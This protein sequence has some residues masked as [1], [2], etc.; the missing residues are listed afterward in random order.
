MC[1]RCRSADSEV[2]VA[3]LQSPPSLPADTQ[4]WREVTTKFIFITLTST[5]NSLFKKCQPSKPV[6]VKIF[7][8]PDG[9]AAAAA[10]ADVA[11]PPVSSS[12]APLVPAASV[13]SSVGSETLG[14]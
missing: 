12:P 6:C 11:R 1:V 2:V 9:A 13:L 8:S 4:Q 10:A 5:S 14:L 3:P 7:V